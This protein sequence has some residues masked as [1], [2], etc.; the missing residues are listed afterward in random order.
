M[1]STRPYQEKARNVAI[2]HAIMASLLENNYSNHKLFYSPTGTGKSYMQMLI[3]E[4]LKKYQR[5]CCILVTRISIMRGFLEMMGVNLN[6]MNLYSIIATGEAYDIYTYTRYR[7]EIMNNELM[8]YD[9]I[10]VDEAHHWML[11]N[12]VPYEIEEMERGSIFL[13]WTATPYRCNATEQREFEDLWKKPYNCIEIEKALAKGYWVM[14][15]C[16]VIPLLDNSNFKIKNGEF[17]NVQVE[18]AISKQSLLPTLSYEVAS[19]RKGPTVVRVNSIKIAHQ[20]SRILRGSQ[21]ITSETNEK[22]RTHILSLLAEDK[23]ILIQIGVVSEGF[24]LPQIQ[25]LFDFA[26]TNSPGNWEQFF[27]RCTRPHGNITKYYF[28]CCRNLEQ[29]AYVL[30]NALDRN[31]FRDVQNGF[32]EPFFGASARVLPGGKLGSKLLRYKKLRYLTKDGI[33]GQFYLL[34]TPP[35]EYTIKQYC[36]IFRPNIP[37]P[38]VARKD[39]PLLS[40]KANYK[41]SGRWFAVEFDEVAKIDGACTSRNKMK[42]TPKMINWWNRSADRFGLAPLDKF[43]P[44]G[45]EFQIL[46]VMANLTKDYKNERISIL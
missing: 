4:E 33:W 30:G 6:G 32:N 11:S 5:S 9:V 20:L 17:D 19:R 14:P 41:N 15:E 28:C 44:V 18:Q 3:K 26:P 8:H 7:N 10:Q 21:V 2:D 22:E 38:I 36:I 35:N 12:T 1:L 31:V 24:N 29:H 40:G 34:E 23:C 27:G 45:R 25:T 16:K 43:K 46:P 37:E 13:G 39:I 42:L